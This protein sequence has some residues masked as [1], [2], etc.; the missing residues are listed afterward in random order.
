MIFGIGLPRSAGQTLG[1]ALQT[2]Y[3]EYKVWHSITG[4]NWHVLDDTAVAAVEVYAPYQWLERHWPGSL[5]IANYRDPESWLGSCERLYGKSQERNYNHPLWKYPPSSW[6]D[7]YN[8]YH[9]QIE[10]RVPE[11][12]LLWWNILED[13]TWDS[14][15]D[16]LDVPVPDAPFPN[17][18]KHGRAP[19]GASAD[20]YWPQPW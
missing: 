4:P 9:E 3:P 10:N 5:F 14:V 1:A 11:H 8:D 2:L 16:F 18:D 12:R 19:E 17:V 20:V 13:P 7:Y 6:L 15:C